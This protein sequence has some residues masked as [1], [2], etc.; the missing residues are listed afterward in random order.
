MSINI[1]NLRRV[2]ATER[3]RVLIYGPPGLGKTS[4]AAE[5]PN[6]VFIQVEDGTPAGLELTSFGRITT[7]DEI[8]DCIGALYSEG[9]EYQ[10]VVLDS[11]DRAE[12]MVWRKL[13]EARSWETIES[14]GYGKGYAEADMYW[15]DI[16]DGL[17]A[18]RYERNMNVVY[19]AHSAIVTVDDPMTQ[20]YSRFDVKLHKRALGIFQDEVDV[21]LFVNQD[22]VIKTDATKT[23]NART[24]AD[25]GGH[26]WIYTTPR[27]SF[28]AKNRYDL[29]DKIAFEKGKG[30][31]KLKAN[32]PAAP[33]PKEEK[34][35]K[36]K[37]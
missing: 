25:G 37:Q 8:M 17:N 28:V 21:I 2:Q 18:L 30:Y 35:K 12:P 19:V 24:R 4:L 5:W 1:S 29:P 13:C 33:E 27:P 7:Y 15:R 36:S 22:I 9:Q 16:I 11:L 23:K 14:P 32:F 10:T 31:E 6:P 26:R 34:T 3:P 20:S